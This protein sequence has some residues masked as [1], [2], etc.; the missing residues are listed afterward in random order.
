MPRYAAWL[1]GPDGSVAVVHS[2]KPIKACS[3][4]EAKLSSYLCDAL[5]SAGD[6]CDAALCEDCRVPKGPELDYCPSH[7]KSDTEYNELD[8]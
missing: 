6:T 7:A 1:K 5:I 3:V 8:W 2:S 4:C